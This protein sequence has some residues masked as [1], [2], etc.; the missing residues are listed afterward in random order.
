MLKGSLLLTVTLAI[1]AT[2]AFVVEKQSLH[3]V[4]EFVLER[5]RSGSCQLLFN[6]E[7]DR[8]RLLKDSGSVITQIRRGSYHDG[9]NGGKEFLHLFGFEE[10][11]ISSEVQKQCSNQAAP[12]NPGFIVQGGSS[13]VPFDNLGYTNTTL[14]AAPSLEVTSLH[15]SGDSVNRVDLVFF[16]DGCKTLLPS[17]SCTQLKRLGRYNRGQGQVPS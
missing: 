14:P 15:H 6:R 13:Y 16:G 12:D 17:I 2:Q 8:F 9:S 4:K 7:V 5:F 3:R 10:D 1:Y 11:V